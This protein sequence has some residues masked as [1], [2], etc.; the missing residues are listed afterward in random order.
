[1]ITLLLLSCKPSELQ[2]D[3]KKAEANPLKEFNL[4]EPN[5]KDSK[6]LEKKVTPAE[7]DASL[8][9]LSKEEKDLLAKKLN[10]KDSKKLTDIYNVNYLDSL[11]SILKEKKEVKIDISENFLLDHLTQNSTTDTVVISYLNIKSPTKGEVATYTYDVLAGDQ[12]IYE[13]TNGKH[14]LKNIEFIEGETTRLRL[15]DIKKRKVITGSFKI[16]TDNKLILN[17]SNEGFFRNKGVIGSNLNIVIKKLVKSKGTTTTIQNDTTYVAKMVNKIST[18]T[19]Y[20]LEDTKKF[21]LEPTINI[22]KKNSFSFPIIITS[23]DD[24]IGWGYWIGTTTSDFETYKSLQDGT[25]EAI[26]GY[27]IQ[28]LKELKP[29]I[30]LPKYEGNDLDI[31]ILNQSLDSRS[32]NFDTNF[33]FYKTDH[34]IPRASKKAEVRLT[35]RSTIYDYTINYRLVTASLVNQSKMVETQVPVINKSILIKMSEND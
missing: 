11:K 10:L 3:L 15:N 33:A 35:N 6:K 31:L 17:I 12:I 14:E 20:T 1:M 13:I 18:D 4:K 22:T 16:M 23:T 7:L 34:L 29:I 25:N 26:I 19:I 32:I 2:A 28:E 30:P 21:K 8:N 9:N 24:L 5:L 27:A